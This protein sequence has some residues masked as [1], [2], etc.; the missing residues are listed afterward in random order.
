MVIGSGAT[1][2]TLLPAMAEEA[3]HVTM[4]Q[5]TPTY[6]IPLPREDAIAN[7][8]K[9]IFGNERG[10]CAY[11]AEER[12]A[13]ANP[14]RTVSAVPPQVA[15][16]MIRKINKSQL[17]EDFP[18]D[19]HFNPPYDPWDQR[20]CVVPDADLF[21]TIRSGKASIVTDRIASFTETGILLES[22]GRTRGRHHRHRNR[23]QHQDHRWHRPHGRRQPGLAT[24][25]RRLPR[26]HAVRCAELRAGH[27]VH[28]RILD[29]E[30]RVAVPVLL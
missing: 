24:G 21:R 25:H 15:R 8:L 7:S 5:R 22:G 4:L 18:V 11:S 26:D 10:I 30:D 13:A 27:R 14:V 12:R 19:V 29:A 23:T 2:V 16:R 6:V 9:K 20:L 17:P 28:Q 1:A 3:V